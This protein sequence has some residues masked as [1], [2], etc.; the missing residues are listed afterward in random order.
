[1]SIVTDTRKA[2]RREICSRL[3]WNRWAIILEDTSLFRITNLGGAR[4]RQ[5]SSTVFITNVTVSRGWI[6]NILQTQ[7]SVGVKWITERWGKE[8]LTSRNSIST[9]SYRAFIRR[10]ASIRT[11]TLASTSTFSFANWST[12]SESRISSTKLIDDRFCNGSKCTEII[13]FVDLLRG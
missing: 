2:D 10:N 4:I 5:D 3:K 1:L 9:V 13:N 8:T 7:V 12:R 11:D 6:A